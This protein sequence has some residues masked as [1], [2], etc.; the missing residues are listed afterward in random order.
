MEDYYRD[1]TSAETVA[2]RFERYYVA[3]LRDAGVGEDEIAS[4]LAA[5][6]PY[7]SVTGL[8]RWLRIRDERRRAAG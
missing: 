4:Y 7:M 5:N 8:L 3:E 6:P 1:G 2:P